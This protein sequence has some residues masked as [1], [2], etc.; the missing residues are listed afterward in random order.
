MTGYPV[1]RPDGRIAVLVLNK[2]PRRPWTVRVAPL[3]G[4][5]DAWTLSAMTYRWHARGAI[6]HPSPDLPPRHTVIAG[7]TVTLP[8][9]SVAVLRT[10]APWTG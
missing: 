4:P 6:G 2:D 1:R 9:M 8:A 7:A 3:S 10:A 5:L